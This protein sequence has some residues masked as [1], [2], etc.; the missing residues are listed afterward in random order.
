MTAAIVNARLG[1]TRLRRK[2]M[3]TIGDL[4]MILHVMRQARASRLIEGIIV[5]TTTRKEDDEI[6]AFCRENKLE[7]FRGSATDPLSRIYECAKTYG[8]D[9]VMRVL[10]DMPFVDP[11][12]IDRC[13][14]VFGTDR[15]DYL[16]NTYE[17]KGD[18]WRVSPCGFPQGN[19]VEI[20]TF[21]A[22]EKIWAEAEK[23]SEREHV[24]PYVLQHDDRFRI[25]C[26]KHDGDLSHI[27]YTVDREEDL[28]FVR[29]VWARLPGGIDVVHLSDVLGVLEKSPELL[30][31][32]SANR[33][34]EGYRLSLRNDGRS[35][36]SSPH[37]D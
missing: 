13:I 18:R 11:D 8:L 14:E 36:S 7:C 17:K 10:A 5:A 26:V 9:P 22:L 31:I 24:F 32:N 4:P 33:F 28:R 15:P 35:L 34:D 27:R 1:S 16:T 3:R 23:T 20:A 21:G 6:A 30:K 29:E 12:I 25:S 19:V 2:V 37:G